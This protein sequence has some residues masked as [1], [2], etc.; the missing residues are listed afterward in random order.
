M[1]IKRYEI[2]NP[3]DKL[4]IIQI[5]K[6]NASYPYTKQQLKDELHDIWKIPYSIINL[7][8]NRTSNNYIDWEESHHSTIR[9]SYNNIHDT[10]TI[11]I[12]YILLQVDCDRPE[13]KPRFIRIGSLYYPIIRY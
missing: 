5:W 2:H 1:T 9:Y 8:F 13:W 11:I 7:L 3:K 10:G 4:D 6:Y 12:A